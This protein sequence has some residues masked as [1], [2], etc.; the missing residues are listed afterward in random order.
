VHDPRHGHPALHIRGQPHPGAPP[1]DP[2]QGA[3]AEITKRSS[4]VPLFSCSGKLSSL[5]LYSV[6]LLPMRN[7]RLS[8][9][10]PLCFGHQ[11]PWPP[12]FTCSAHSPSRCIPFPSAASSHQNRNHQT[13][14][15]KMT[16]G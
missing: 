4:N 12:P 2:L 5:Y 1:R 16:C 6:S 13:N 15:V 3:S 11:P 10:N 7:F 9:P 14:Q 8:P